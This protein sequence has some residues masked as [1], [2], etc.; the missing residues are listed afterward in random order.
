M[1]HLLWSLLVLVLAGCGGGREPQPAP[2]GKLV[3]ETWDAAYI[4]GVKTGYYHTTIREV[5]R[6]GR[7]AHASTLEM[8][9][10]IKRFSDVVNLRMQ[11]GTEED[12]DGKVLGVSLTQFADKDKR[13]VK[14]GTVKGGKLLLRVGDDPREQT[15]P[16]DD[17]VLGLY[18][19][20]R[21]FQ[22]RRLKPGDT[23][24]YF[25]YELSLPP[26]AATVKVT[27]TAKEPEEV[28]VLE[29]RQKDGKDVVEHVKRKLLRVEAAP[30]K[31][32][33]GGNAITLP[34]LVSWLDGDFQP[35]RSQMDMPGLG[36]ITLYRTTEA[37]AR[38]DGGA[39][40]LLPDLGL[41][42][43]IFLDKPVE[44]IH[45]L[46][47]VVYRITVKDD[48]NPTTV[49]L[50]DDRQ[51]VRN[52]KG[53]TF[54][55]VVKAVKP[56]PAEKPGQVKDEYL[57]S[58]FFLNSD[59]PKIKELA[60]QVAGDES[61]AWKKAVRIEKWVHDNM[62][63]NNGIGF[64]T[65]GQIARDL[66]GDCRQ[67]AMLSA[68]LCRASGVPA[69]TALGLVY[70]E[71]KRRPVLAFHMWTEVWVKG[72]WLPLDATLGMAGVGPGHL[73]IAEHDWTDTQTLAPLLPVLRA[74][75]KIKAEVVSAE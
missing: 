32:E 75:G 48:D 17:R 40:A 13:L 35:V 55:L 71:E 9:L 30:G 16:W 61:D 64:V 7:K 31:V 26:P 5:E 69:R 43:L 49:F 68:A 14:T 67:H 20:D 53:D 25:N 70:G 45:Q 33:I 63:P 1:K 72:Q 15:V 23:L 50:R 42:N 4:E 6:D 47:E 60:R 58:S 2:A 44:R 29:V 10:T 18:K 46:R 66:Q 38:Q 3:K 34:K 51:S 52:A 11:T 74:L 28:D 37:V 19:Q 21:L 57:K 56:E 39:P 41:D 36:K 54:E 27:V 73:K 65:A 12:A 62:K 22:E 59:D 8:S 24:E